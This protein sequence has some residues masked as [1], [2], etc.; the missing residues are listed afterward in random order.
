MDASTTLG[1]IRLPTFPVSRYIRYNRARI[2][3]LLCEEK[4]SPRFESLDFGSMI[5]RRLLAFEMKSFRD[6]IYRFERLIKRIIEIYDRG[7][8]KKKKLSDDVMRPSGHA[9]WRH[10]FAFRNGQ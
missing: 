7:K 2:T 6:F 5:F 4:K 9:N 1:L 8:K 10:G 3:F